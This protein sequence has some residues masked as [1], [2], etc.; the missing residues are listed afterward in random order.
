MIVM[1]NICS[2][3]P[4]LWS[5]LKFGAKIT[6]MMLDASFV[7]CSSI[8]YHPLSYASFPN[9]IYLQLYFLAK[10]RYKIPNPDI[11]LITQAG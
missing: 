1:L 4:F 7:G 8:I 3:P 9:T 5:A 10:W 11:I 2:F 6:L